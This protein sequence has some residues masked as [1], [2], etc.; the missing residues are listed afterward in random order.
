MYCPAW[1]RKFRLFSIVNGQRPEE[2]RIRGN[3]S[4]SGFHFQL[5]PSG[6]RLPGESFTS[7]VKS[8]FW[9]RL[10]NTGQTAL[11]AATGVSLLTAIPTTS[12][13]F[14]SSSGTTLAKVGTIAGKVNNLGAQV[15]ADVIQTTIA[16]KPSIVDGVIRN[17]VA[18]GETLASDGALFSTA[19]GILSKASLIT[20]AVG[21]GLEGG[22]AI[23]CR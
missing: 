12:P 22:F 16:P 11:N 3:T 19:S 13:A 10:G 2:R 7:C 18:S 8:A 6:L 14:I 17:S 4:G 1:R 9:T 21:L 20:F 5:L 15:S 23:S